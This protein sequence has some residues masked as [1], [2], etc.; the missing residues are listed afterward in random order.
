MLT[1]IAVIFVAVVSVTAAIEYWFWLRR[2]FAVKSAGRE[3]VQ[4][5][6]QR[7]SLLTESL[8]AVGAILVLAG[9]GITI[10]QHWLS[11]TN[12]ARFGILLAS[13]FAS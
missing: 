6:K 4:R 3:G 11:V 1:L 12:W 8:A 2:R 9:S 13:R 5:A 7:L 10:S